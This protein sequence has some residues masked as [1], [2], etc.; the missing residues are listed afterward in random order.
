MKIN[1]NRL[2]TQIRATNQLVE[3]SLKKQ[4]L[5]NKIFYNN[6]YL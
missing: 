1:Y 4:K 2:Q 3:E 5:T 6:P